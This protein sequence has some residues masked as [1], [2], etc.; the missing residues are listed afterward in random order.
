M[1]SEATKYTCPMHPEIVSTNPGSCSKCGMKLEKIENMQSIF[2]RSGG[3]T[4]GEMR[5]ETGGHKTHSETYLK[6]RFLISV[7]LTIL[8][9]V[10]SPLVTDWLGLKFPYPSQ[11]VV[12]FALATF[13][14]FYCGIPF[15]EMAKGEIKTRNLGMMALVSLAVLSGYFFSV[16]ATF[17][18][19]GESLYWEI[20]ILVVAFLFGHWVEI[21]AVKST[22][23][24]LKE[25][26]TLLPD[27]AHLIGDKDTTDVETATLKK[28][29]RLLVKPG[30]KIPMDGR[31][32]DGYSSVN[33]ALITGESRPVTKQVGSEV[34][35]GSMNNDGSLVV[36][37]TKTGSETFIGQIMELVRHAQLSKPTVQKLEDKAAYILTVVAVLVSLST[38]ILWFFVFPQGAVFASTLAILVIVIACPPALGLAIPTVTTLTTSLAAK[39]GILIKDMTAFEVFRKASFVVFDKTGTLTQGTFMVENI[40]P[41]KNNDKEAIVEMASGVEVFSQHAIA[42]GIVN[43]AKN[44]KYVIPKA[45]NFLSIAGKGAKGKIGNSTILVGNQLLLEEQG[46]SDKRGFDLIKLEAA[47]KTITFVAKDK[48]LQ[49]GMI[50]GDPLRLE[51]KEAISL[52]AQRGIKTALLTGDRLEIGRAVAFEL[53][54]DS[55]FAEVLP[56]EKVAKMKQLQE[57]GEI[58]VMVGDGVNDAASLAQANVGIAIGAG[59]AVAVETSSLVLVKNDPRDVARALDLSRLNYKKMIQNLVY[60]TLYNILALPLASGVLFPLGILLRPEWSALFMSAS[61]LVVV[62]NALTLKRAR[63]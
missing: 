11:E 18:F 15:Y 30:E 20:S 33:E 34:I 52:L 61:S 62:V 27:Q 35:G 42:Q 57:Q 47:G 3:R 6:S 16:A 21:K 26:A 24:A 7:P 59:T 58:V 19:A 40:I 43:Y 17:L 2:P 13:I 53:G 48:S 63:L 14:V 56:E 1:N 10:M 55:F 54:V 29:D 46:V 23:R 9:I 44:K 60:A 12:L 45:T 4:N 39:H 8:V 28:G 5:I 50:L 51:A 41:Y 38:F 36:E 37:V 31:V 32:V 25:L 22:G 49:G